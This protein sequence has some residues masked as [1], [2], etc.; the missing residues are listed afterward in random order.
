MSKQEK[1]SSNGKSLK[2]QLG[3]FSS[4]MILVG[5]VIGSGI[6]N[7]PGKVA[8]AA[9][10][11]GPNLLAWVIAGFAATM[12]ALVYA[13][14]SPMFPKA[15][16]AYVFI[17]EAFGSMA[18]FL[19]GWSMIFGSLMPVIAMLALGFINYLRFF[20]PAIDLTTSRII[21]SVIVLVLSFINI[22]GVKQGSKVQN[23]F[24]VGK[25][26]ALAL[27]I[28]GGIF[29]IKGAYFQPVVGEAGWSATFSAA[30]PA[31]LAFGG[32]YVLSYMSEEV[33]NPSKN[34]PKAT[35]FGMLIVIVVNVLINV[36]AIGNLPHDQL[37]ASEK[38]VADVAMAIFGPIGAAIVSVGALVSIFGSLN[39]SVMGL[40]R[41][42]FAMAREKLLFS[43]FHLSNTQ[44]CYKTKQSGY[45][46]INFFHRIF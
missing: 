41:L 40:P 23:I 28:V 2:R 35:I 46:Y 11:S 8:A 26:S 16:G 5:T 38:P 14:L 24:T 19:Y 18:A 42:S 9:G 45:I 39:S 32:Y 3:L 22:L 10:G 44:H 21:G 15:G 12:F 33:E 4:M 13:E 37:A 6:F 17:K 31:V 30:V 25:L 1:S 43:F 34:L 20:F 7:T 27:V 36:V 29:T